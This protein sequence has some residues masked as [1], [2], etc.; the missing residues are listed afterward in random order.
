[1]VCIPA[2]IAASV[3]AEAV[4][5]MNTESKVRKAIIDGMDPQEAYLTFGKF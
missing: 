2:E 5:A 4:V 3:A 1:M